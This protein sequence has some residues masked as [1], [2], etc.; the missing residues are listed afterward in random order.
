MIELQNQKDFKR[1]KPV[2]NEEGLE[3]TRRAQK[4][5]E[6]EECNHLYP[7]EILN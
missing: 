5:Y 4:L 2:V 1:F 7:K 6:C 3:I